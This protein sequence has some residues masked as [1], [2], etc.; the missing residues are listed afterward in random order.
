MRTEQD[1]GVNI[2]TKSGLTVIYEG[3][4]KH[5]KDNNNG[6]SSSDDPIIFIF[7]SVK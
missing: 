5:D 1:T 2:W 6:G 4:V 3:N 7:S